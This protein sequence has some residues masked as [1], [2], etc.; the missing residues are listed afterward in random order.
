MKKLKLFCDV[1]GETFKWLAL[2]LV[3]L[4]LIICLLLDMGITIK[5][6]FFHIIGS[7]STLLLAIVA[8]VALGSWK[9]ESQYLLN[10]KYALNVSNCLINLEDSINR[11]AT[12]VREVMEYKPEHRIINYKSYIHSIKKDNIKLRN[13]VKALELYCSVSLI[14]SC[15]YYNDFLTKINYNLYQILQADVKACKETEAFFKLHTELIGYFVR[16]MVNNTIEIELN[17][18]KL[19]INRGLR[20]ILKS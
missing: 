7:V 15:D 5:V 6:E 3:M 8:I 11:L 20:K 10:Q 16:G 18:S 2:C 19:E 14:G 13:S 12:R 4:F 1:C 9:R 17:K